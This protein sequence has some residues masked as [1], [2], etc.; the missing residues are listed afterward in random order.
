MWHGIRG[1]AYT[2]T[3]HCHWARVVGCDEVGRV[4]DVSRRIRVVIDLGCIAIG[5]SSLSVTFA[6]DCDSLSSM[7]HI[8]VRRHI[9]D[10]TLRDLANGDELLECDGHTVH[11]DRGH[12]ERGGSPRA[13]LGGDIPES[14]SYTYR[15]VADVATQ[16]KVRHVH[17]LHAVHNVVQ[18]VRCTPTQAHTKQAKVWG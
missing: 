14:A 16:A 11:V 18:D 3:C 10:D 6:F 1:Q 17:V 8:D 15:L 12:V 13:Q 9:D 2:A 4:Y 7:L 5:D